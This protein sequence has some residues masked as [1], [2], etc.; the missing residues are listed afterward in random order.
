MDCM[1]YNSPGL[2]E[3]AG[4]VVSFAPGILGKFFGVVEGDVV[5]AGMVAGGADGRRFRSFVD[6]AADKAFPFDGLVAF[7]HRPVL[8]ALKVLDEAVVMGLLD[9]GY[10]AEMGGY[11]VEAFLLCNLGESRVHVD[12]FRQF[13]G[14]GAGEVLGGG[15]YYAG[16]G[17]HGSRHLTSLK[18]FEVDFGV[19]EFVGRGFIEHFGDGEIPLFGR[20]LGVERIAGVR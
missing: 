17:V 11:L 20:L 16:V 3:E 14:G 7:P 1:A 13:L 15:A 18:K 10:G 6:V 4:V 9:G 19:T 5:F 8:H 12:T 2:L